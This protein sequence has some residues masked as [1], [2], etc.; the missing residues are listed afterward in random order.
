MNINKQINDALDTLLIKDLRLLILNHFPKC[1]YCDDHEFLC[2]RLEWNDLTFI[3][4]LCCVSLCY[5][6]ICKN[7]SNEST[8]CAGFHKQICFS[9]VKQAKKCRLCDKQICGDIKSNSCSTCMI[10]CNEE[11]QCNEWC[12]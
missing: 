8:R 4:S 5:E 7:C 10:K 6:T 9:H 11:Y 1:S 12:V 3:K 2:F